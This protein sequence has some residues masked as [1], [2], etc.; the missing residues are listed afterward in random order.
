[1]N[2]EHFYAQLRQ[3]QSIQLDDLLAYTARDGEF[4]GF[5]NGT[6]FRN[7]AFHTLF[8]RDL[9]QL[10]QA[11]EQ[12]DLSIFEAYL[13]SAR[14]AAYKFLEKYH[15]NK[16]FKKCSA[17]ISDGFYQHPPVLALV[18]VLQCLKD[19]EQQ[20][21]QLHH[22]LKAYLC[23]EVKNRLPEVLQEK[24]ETTFS[25][26]IRTLS[27]ALKGEQGQRFAQYVQSRYPLILVDEFQDTNQDQD[28]MRPVSGAIRS[29]IK[30]AA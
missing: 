10:L 24:G 20:F 22:H 13:G 4:Y 15:Q 27:E 12:P 7:D 23:H 6:S 25:Q 3:A 17:A 5:I 14:E 8:C 19:Y 30:M 16:I 28:D 2:V 18:E 11:L 9:P 21:A 26:Q 29:V 1:M